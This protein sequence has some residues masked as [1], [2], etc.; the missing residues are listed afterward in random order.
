MNARTVLVETGCSG[1]KKIKGRGRGEDSMVW[2]G[3]RDPSLT[4]LPL[5]THILTRKRLVMVSLLSITGTG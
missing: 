5:V 2:A 1:E 4:H 3:S